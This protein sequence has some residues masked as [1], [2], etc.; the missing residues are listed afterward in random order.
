[1]YSNNIKVDFP[2]NIKRMK[3][4]IC[5]FIFLM[6]WSCN[7]K[8]KELNKNVDGEVINLI[9]FD[10]VV[11]ISLTDVYDS[12]VII[13]LKTKSP[14]GNIERIFFK[15]DNMYIWDENGGK[16]WGFKSNGDSLFCIDKQGKGPDEYIRI[17]DV[18]I[19]DLGYI[20]ILDVSQHKLLSYDINTELR[21]SKKFDKWVHN[22]CSVDGYDYLFSATPDQPEGHYVDVMKNSEKIESYF[23]TTH[24]W[25]FSH[26]SFLPVKDSVFFTRFYD[27]RIYYFKDGNLN[28]GY[29]V[30]FGNDIAFMEKLRDAEDLEKHK[31]LM[32][33]VRYTGDIRHLSISDTYLTFDYSEPIKDWVIQTSF[34]YNKKTKKGLSFKSFGDSSDEYFSVGTPIA[35]DGHYFY[36]LIEPWSI[37]EAHKRQLQ[38]R[39]NFP[40][41]SNL[42]CLLCRFLLK[43]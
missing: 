13:P 43:I 18:S 1:M 41:E 42:N 30:N 16:V 14:I 12:V 24:N 28:T 25:H 10:N 22:Y 35:S 17:D 4:I 21:E 38:E 6:I 33:S 34:I 8:D 26:T 36:A 11:T 19:S 32:K 39:V 29:S 5:V 7:Q 2:H 27:D 20:N 23:A 3:N 15:N 37:D 9:A 40:L 31:E